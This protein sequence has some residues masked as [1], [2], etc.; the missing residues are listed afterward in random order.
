MEDSPLP[1]PRKRAPSHHATETEQG[2]VDRQVASPE[3]PALAWA[4]GGGVALRRDQ[5]AA[6]PSPAQEPLAWAPG[7]M[8]RAVAME[9]V[10]APGLAAVEEQEG[11]DASAVVGG[12]EGG[13]NC[14]SGDDCGMELLYTLPGHGESTV[15]APQGFAAEGQEGQDVAH[16]P[17]VSVSDNDLE[18]QSKSPGGETGHTRASSPKASGGLFLESRLGF[19]AEPEGK[20]EG[21]AMVEPCSDVGVSKVEAASPLPVVGG[22]AA[23]AKSLG[24]GEST[25]PAH[26]PTAGDI[27]PTAGDISGEEEGR[28][29]G[30]GEEAGGREGQMRL[31]ELDCLLDESIEKYREDLAA[32]IEG[33]GDAGAAETPTP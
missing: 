10:V 25:T 21:G 32:S 27:P 4:P 23:E 26:P 16:L 30:G 15:H 19:V 1:P 18:A 33:G 5:I 2:A 11:A 17:E 22:A 14:E 20:A 24:E 8:P 28:T 6:A 3:S 9:E 31:E 29:A 12:S 13:D 7:G